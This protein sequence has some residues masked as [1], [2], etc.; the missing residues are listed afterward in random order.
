EESEEDLQELENLLGST[1]P[2]VSDIN[3]SE[4]FE[5]D[6]YLRSVMNRVERHWTPPFKDDKLYTVVSFRI[7]ASGKV[8]DVKV[9]K[10]SGRSSLDNQAVRAIKLSAPFPKLPPGYSGNVLNIA[11]TLRPTTK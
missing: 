1:S 9:T 6:W 8:S 10:G 2:S 4:G 3:V 5:Y 11:Y 7:L